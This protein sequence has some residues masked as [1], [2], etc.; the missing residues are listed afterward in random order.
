MKTFI[1]ALCD[2]GPIGAHHTPEI[3]KKYKYFKRAREF[4][5]E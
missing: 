5:N 1:Y 3:N 2:P 4:I